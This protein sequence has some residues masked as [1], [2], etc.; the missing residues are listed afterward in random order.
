[1]QI[2]L[3]SLDHQ[4]KAINAILS[5]L[6]N[7]E[8]LVAENIKSNVWENPTINPPQNITRENT[9]YDSF[10][11]QERIID[12]KME[13]G[14]GK[15][16]V[17]TRL[18]FELFHLYGLNKFI[19]ITPGVAIKEGVINFMKSDYAKR[20][21]NE[22]F[23]NYKLNSY[24]VNKGDFTTK[25]GRKKI[26]QELSSFIS[27]NY[28]FHKHESG[29][30]N[31]NCLILNSGMLTSTSMARDD[32]DQ[33]LINSINSPLNALKEIKP[34][35]IIDEPH[36][37]KKNDT[38]WKNISKLCP[39]LIFRFGA[40]FAQ[41]AP[42]G[43][44]DYTNLVYDLNAVRSFNQG[45]V[46][47]V[48]ISYP[49][50]S[51]D[52][53]KNRYKI[54]KID[55]RNSAK[56][57]ILKNM[58][59]KKEYRLK[60]QECLNIVDRAF[61]GNIYLDEIKNA[62]SAVLSNELE[63]SPG[64]DILP[65]VFSD[66]YQE[67][68][69]KKALDEHFKK[70][71]ENF[72]RPNTNNAPK[73]KTLSLFFIENIESFRDEE[74]LLKEGWLRKTFT[75]LLKEKLK[76][77]FKK[78]KNENGRKGEYADFL[79]AS[80]NALQLCLG[81]YFARDNDK[82]SDEA[83]VAEVDDILR[84]KEKMLTFKDERGNWNLRRFLFSKWTLREGW[85]NP[86]V[87]VLTKIRSS[88]SEI[89]K[90]QEVGRGLRL[91]VDE[92]GNR[93]TDQEFSLSFLIDY[94]EKEFANKLIGEINA[95][96]I[97]ETI[98][99]NKL[100]DEMIEKI[101]GKSGIDKANFL[102]ELDNLGI[103]DR[104]NNFNPS[105]TINGQTKSG[106]EWFIEKCPNIFG[107]TLQKGKV[108]TQTEIKKPKKT[109]LRIKNWEKIESLWKQITK[110]FIVKYQDLNQKEMEKLLNGFLK[111]EN[112]TTEQNGEI[113][114]FN[115]ENENAK[116]VLK[117]NT[118]Y[119][120]KNIENMKYGVFLKRL[121]E[122]TNL[123]LNLLHKRICEIFVKEK[124][125]DDLINPLSLQKLKGAFDE[126]FIEL[127]AQ[128]YEYDT[129]D[130]QACVSLLDGNKFVESV[131]SNDIGIYGDPDIKVDDRY[132]FEAPARYDSDIEHEVLKKTPPENITVFGKIPKKSIKFPTYTGNTTT[133]DFLYCIQ[134]NDSTIINA[135]IEAKG[136]DPAALSELEKAVLNSQ[137]KIA[138]M[139]ENTEMK[140]ITQASEAIDFLETLLKSNK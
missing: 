106:F 77:L 58:Q 103:I 135:L 67:L 126:T 15:T 132:L 136:K 89:S 21:F 57:V 13:T 25:R 39:Q 140:T 116:V 61:E 102:R 131:A 63:I 53:A 65:D 14:T 110:R 36:R 139:L 50:L 29:R 59:T 27:N 73:I 40:T 48:E 32:Y 114:T 124:N 16:Y 105:V 20:H 45:L 82:K 121:H 78:Y 23:K 99:K 22:L 71:A 90:I 49:D 47:K 123:P 80:L 54:M 33:T 10:C 76:E 81:G 2:Q 17:Y 34:I 69:L 12:V 84:N 128:K 11:P 117:E 64:M 30:G 79:Q 38:A 112:F 43:K 37:F 3:E 60:T 92:T 24:I 88:G 120:N 96:S 95:D 26:P 109:E 8:Q 41:N 108:K 75:K 66:N 113:K 86:N 7:K 119:V 44:K 138:K 97:D 31:I 62:N 101:R 35:I 130:Y 118:C 19:I 127:F 70:E 6:G 87:F 133:P 5:A 93:I 104:A 68:I 94:S 51:E 55:N 1:M 56:C 100:T 115:I 85:D 107:E 125:I 111:L 46:K 28:Y 52:K 137:E 134:R 98:D 129:L 4:E 91:P 122:H 42:K 83:I 74:G 72:L 18:C 9:L